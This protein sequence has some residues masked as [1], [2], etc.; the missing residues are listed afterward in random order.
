MGAL[1]LSRSR[2]PT[3]TLIGS[4]CAE[5]ASLPASADIAGVFAARMRDAAI[6]ATCRSMRPPL[7]SAQFTQPRY[8]GYA[9]SHASREMDAERPEINLVNQDNSRCGA[10]LAT[11]FAVIHCK[12]SLR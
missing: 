7:K 2:R 4:A 6:I 11:S 10:I 1:Y 3:S 9:V 5:S 12:T 8:V